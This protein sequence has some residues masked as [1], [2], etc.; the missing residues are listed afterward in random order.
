MNQ[1]IL[2]GKASIEDMLNGTLKNALNEKVTIDKLAS[3]IIRGGWP[4]YIKTPVH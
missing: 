3:L 2:R 4:S 1:E